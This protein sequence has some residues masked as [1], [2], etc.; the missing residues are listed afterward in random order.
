MVHFV[1]MG[2]GPRGRNSVS[3]HTALRRMTCCVGASAEKCEDWHTGLRDCSY[4]NSLFSRYP[5]RVSCVWLCVVCTCRDRRWIDLFF[6]FPRCISCCRTTFADT[7][8]DRLDMRRLQRERCNRRLCHPPSLRQHCRDVRRH[9]PLRLLAPP[10]SPPLIA[11]HA[12]DS[13][14]HGPRRAAA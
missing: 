11:A 10:T 9:V 6:T 5:C 3:S 8:F 1:W 4:E 13:G 7:P 14:H 2:H 12:S